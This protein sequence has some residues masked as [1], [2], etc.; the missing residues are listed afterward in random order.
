VQYHPFKPMVLHVDFQ[1]VDANTVLTR[2]VPVH[3][4]GE[5]NSPAVKAEN[6]LATHVVNELELRGLPGDLPEAID[7]DLSGLKKG[8]SLHLSD[9]TLPKG[10]KAL[11]HG[12]KDPVLVAVVE[13]KAEE[14]AAPAAAAAAVDPK[15]AK[16]K[17]KK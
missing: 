4:K 8:K 14:E 12:R 7:V 1:R 3:Y 13:Q 11:T 15:A 10:V 9:I 2:K 16:G 6:C 5:E 17:G